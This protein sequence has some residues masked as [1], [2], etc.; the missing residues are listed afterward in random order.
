MLKT[1]EDFRKRGFGSFLVHKVVEATLKKGLVPYVHIEDE[2]LHSQ[3]FFTK[4]GFTKY[5]R[6][7]WINH[8]PMGCSDKKLY[9]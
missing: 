7:V 4:L 9:I 3:E 1:R 6:A 2:N 8:Y 5:S